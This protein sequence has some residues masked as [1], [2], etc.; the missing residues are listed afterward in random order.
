MLCPYRVK[1]RIGVCYGGGHTCYPY[2]SGIVL[3]LTGREE[4]VLSPTRAA[5]AA[6]LCPPRLPR[7]SNRAPVSS[8]RR[9]RASQ[10]ARPPHHPAASPASLLRSHIQPGMRRGESL[11]ALLPAE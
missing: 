9:G 8:R 11:Q 6:L 10:A 3:V 2:V 1:T 4:K 5:Q 7:T